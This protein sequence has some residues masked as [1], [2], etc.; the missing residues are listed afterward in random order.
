MGWAPTRCRR[1]DDRHPRAR[2]ELRGDFG[3]LRFVV[4]DEHAQAWS[5]RR[6]LVHS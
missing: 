6:A 3:D 1:D 2:E 4:D 5:H